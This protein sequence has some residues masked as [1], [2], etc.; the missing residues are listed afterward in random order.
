M[1]WSLPEEKKIQKLEMFC[2]LYKMA[3]TYHPYKIAL[4]DGQK[5]KLQKALAEKSAG[6]NDTRQTGTNRSRRRA[7]FDQHSNQPNEK[8]G[9]RAKGRR[10]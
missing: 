3:T 7:P 6:R 8:S 5:K 9:Q 1:N 10:S 2:I 4:T